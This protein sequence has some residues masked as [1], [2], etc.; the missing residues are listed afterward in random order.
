MR[1]YEHLVKDPSV[2]VTATA[3]VLYEQAVKDRGSSKNIILTENA[4]VLE[5]F[6]NLSRDPQ[7]I[8]DAMHPVL[9][10]KK[11]VLGYYGALAEWFDYDLIRALAE[12]R[13]DCEIVLIG[14]DWG[15]C[16][17][18]SGIAELKNVTILPPVDYR[19]LTLYAAWFDVAMVPFLVNEV[20]LAT[21]PVKLFEY[22]AMGLPTVSV[23]L[24][25]CR[26]YPPVLI[27]EGHNGFIEKIEEA[28]SLGDDAEYKA[29]LQAEAAK[30][31][32]SDRAAIIAEHLAS[33]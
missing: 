11:P 6:E 19:E 31:T 24:P 14:P 18:K 16:V 25:E 26:K 10:K 20:T 28:L 27:G 15:D 8:P 3:S 2:L 17:E 13:P 21:S 30:N 12:A 23:D 33:L 9:D 22:M 7:Q 32:W 5:D 29:Q 4:V 1:L